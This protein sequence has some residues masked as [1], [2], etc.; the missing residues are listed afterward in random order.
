MLFIFL[1]IFPILCI[2]FLGGPTYVAGFICLYI[3]TVYSISGDLSLTLFITYLLVLFI[4]KPLLNLLPVQYQDFVFYEPAV[5]QSN[6]INVQIR[7]VVFIFFFLSLLVPRSNIAVKQHLNTLTLP[8]ISFLLLLFVV[9][10]G[11]VFGNYAV[12]FS[13]SFFHL[14][15]ILLVFPAVVL[16][17]I[18]RSGDRAHM[19]LIRRVFVHFILFVLVLEG[20]VACVQYVSKKPL[21]INIETG[22]LVENVIAPED[23]AFRSPG[24]LEHPNYLGANLAML[25]PLA[26]YFSVIGYIRGRKKMQLKTLVYVSVIGSLGL[27]T[28]YSRWAW[29]SFACMFT[30]VLL[31]S[32]NVFFGTVNRKKKYVYIVLTVIIC[33]IS[34]L[35]LTRFRTLTTLNGR[36][37]IL[38]S[39]LQIVQFAPAWGLGPGNSS[40]SLVPYQNLESYSSS[41]KAAHN[42]L[43]LIAAESG[44]PALLLFIVPILWAAL[45]GIR[46]W[47][48]V[49]KDPFLMSVAVGLAIFLFC[50]VAYPLYTFDPS[51]EVFLLLLS[52]FSVFLFFRDGKSSK[53]ELL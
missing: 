27:I 7:T 42:T 22:F 21:L 17:L 46:K 50:S 43:A 1:Y 51:L 9:I 20:A 6:P 36:L 24:T 40:I 14:M 52:V 25:L 8:V 18:R 39:Y 31:C 29:I 4:G 11:Q 16:F 34:F 45:W 32:K 12:V 37:S 19:Q 30:L 26:I 3:L 5:T 2:I 48:S 47:E 33:A 41:I 13:W 28:S 44:T 15:Q 49:Q 53:T 23:G 38:Q 35:I 10:A